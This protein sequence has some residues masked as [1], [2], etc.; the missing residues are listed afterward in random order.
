MAAITLYKT[1]HTQLLPAILTFPLKKYD[2]MINN[3][4]INKQIKIFAIN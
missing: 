4:K 1:L 2:E 3:N